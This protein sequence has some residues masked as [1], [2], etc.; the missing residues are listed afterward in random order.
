MSLAD[1]HLLLTGPVLGSE[2]KVSSLFLRPGVENPE[3][4]IEWE[5]A[6][7][8]RE[9]SLLSQFLGKENQRASVDLV[10]VDV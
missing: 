8:L 6:C 4:H 9:D 3:V 5:L 2:E 1:S 7:D 10:T